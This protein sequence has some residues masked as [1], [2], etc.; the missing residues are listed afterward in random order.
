MISPPENNTPP[1]HRPDKILI[2]GNQGFVGRHLEKRLSRKSPE[3][4]VMGINRSRCDL[5]SPVESTS[6]TP[7]LDRGTTIVFLAVLKRQFGDSLDAFRQNIAMITNLCALLETYPVGGMVFLS[8]T[9][10][11]GE[12]IHNRNITEDTPVQPTSYY[13]MAK[14]V[15][16]RLLWKSLSRQSQTPLLILRPPTLYGP[17]DKGNTY[18]PISFL[19]AALREEPVTLWGDGTELREFI[20]IDD[21]VEIVS[22]LALNPTP[23]LVNAVSGKSHSFCRVLSLVEAVSGKILEKTHRTRTK[24]KV[25]HGFSKK[26]LEELMGTFPFTPLEDGLR[27]TWRHLKNTPI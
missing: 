18:G 16:E 23:G 27:T 6:L 21:L 8:S 13:G 9:A 2:L 24:T 15:S 20:Y 11:Y 10:V 26:G 14:F 19:N 3:V 12:D 4:T 5:T 17:G 1:S 7:F 25:D 22:R